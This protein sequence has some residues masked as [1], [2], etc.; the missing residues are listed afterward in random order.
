MVFDKKDTNFYLNNFVWKIF[1][2]KKN[3]F[4]NNNV[5]KNATKLTQEWTRI[6]HQ[7]RCFFD[8]KYKRVWKA[9]QGKS[10]EINRQR[11]LDSR[12]RLCSISK[13]DSKLEQVLPIFFL[14]VCFCYWFLYH[15]K[16]RTIRNKIEQIWIY[17]PIRNNIQS[18]QTKRFVFVFYF[19]SYR[20]LLFLRGNE[21]MKENDMNE[22]EKENVTDL[23]SPLF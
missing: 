7:A 3:F 22:R 5:D 18:N 15:K 10:H 6:I 13:W 2:S 23:F 8:I 21:M 17:I 20:N 16:Y 19:I 14:F 12:T 1:I 9:F 4:L 11:C